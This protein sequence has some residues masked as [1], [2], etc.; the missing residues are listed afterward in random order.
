[1]AKNPDP[2]QGRRYYYKKSNEEATPPR[3]RRRMSRRPCTTITKNGDYLDGEHKHAK[4]GRKPPIPGTQLKSLKLREREE[5]FS[6]DFQESWKT[7]GG[8]SKKNDPNINTNPT[9]KTGGPRLWGRGRVQYPSAQ[10]HSGGRSKKGKKGGEVPF[11]GMSMNG[12]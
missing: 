4:K 9:S 6:Q 11:P 10:T 5:R 8:S 12:H 1:V 3:E 7:C 2:T